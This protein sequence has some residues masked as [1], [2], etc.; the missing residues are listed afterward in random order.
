VRAINSQASD[1]AGHW[2]FQVDT[3]GDGY[4]A[5]VDVLLV[6]NYLNDRATSR[7]SFADGAKGE[8]DSN[9]SFTIEVDTLAGTT[10]GLPQ[11][12]ALRASNSAGIQE[13]VSLEKP[14]AALPPA[15]SA[16]TANP[17][18]MSKPA[19]TNGSNTG[20]C[21]A[22]AHNDA[23]LMELMDESTAAIGD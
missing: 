22:A 7:R 19:T 20:P 23:A 8:S 5:P 6:I 1:P 11:P 21:L 16:R 3:N 10:I 4:L 9:L 17:R 13:N 15:A 2:S 12:D 18:A 14:L